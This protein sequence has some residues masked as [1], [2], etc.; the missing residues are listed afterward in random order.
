MLVRQ[1]PASAKASAKEH[2]G[3]R[4]NLTCDRVTPLRKAW[5]HSEVLCDTSDVGLLRCT[6]S[7][8]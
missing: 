3:L 5:Q 2:Q 8:Q 7:L 6:T 4:H 1:R